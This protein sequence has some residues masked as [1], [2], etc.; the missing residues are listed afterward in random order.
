MKSIEA[1][2]PPAAGHWPRVD[3]GDGVSVQVVSCNAPE[4]HIP[5]LREVFR[6]W[7]CGSMN[8][9]VAI[10]P[11]PHTV[12]VRPRTVPLVA[13]Q[14]HE[15]M[16]ECVVCACSLLEEGVGGGRVH[17]E[18]VGSG[19]LCFV[20]EEV[21]VDHLERG[22]SVW[23]QEV[24]V[25]EHQLQEGGRAQVFVAVQLGARHQHVLPRLER[26]PRH[27]PVQ[28]RVQLLELL[29]V[30]HAVDRRHVAHELPCQRVSH[31]VDPPDAELLGAVGKVVG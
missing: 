7:V 28:V 24:V 13:H 29:R 9:G 26:N 30:G 11:R 31:G 19:W 25:V 22:G 5:P 21:D 17:D 4:E 27:C 6:P 10:P 12:A 3:V 20:Q 1:L 15:V 2:L 23:L 14:L 8:V 18:H 16:H